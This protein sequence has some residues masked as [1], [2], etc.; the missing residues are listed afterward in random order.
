M[1]NTFKIW[2]LVVA[3]SISYGAIYSQDTCNAKLQFLNNSS[4]KKAGESGTYYRL[5]LINNSESQTF[6]IEVENA[7][8]KTQ[9]NMRGVNSSSVELS[10]RITSDKKNKL[11]SNTNNRSAISKGIYK[12]SNQV[13][14]NK[15]EEFIFYVR[16]D[17]PKGTRF[18]SI[19]KSIVTITSNNCKDFK[20]SKELTTEIIDGE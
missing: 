9:L 5:V 3:F 2:F 1:E 4:S 15:N 18:G 8:S 17:V 13:S 14:L 20:I 6:N 10:S 19:N 11:K 16:L 12:K 7:I